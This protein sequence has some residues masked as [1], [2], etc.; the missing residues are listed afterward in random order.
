MRGSDCLSQSQPNDDEQS[1][2]NDSS[3]PFCS[4]AAHSL[5]F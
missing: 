4:G 5:E 1:K 2:V 3:P